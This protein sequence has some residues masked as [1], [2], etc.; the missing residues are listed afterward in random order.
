MNLVD[1]DSGVYAAMMAA[2]IDDVADAELGSGDPEINSAIDVI[3]EEVTNSTGDIERKEGQ[4]DEEYKQMVCEIVGAA[5]NRLKKSGKLDVCFERL[6]AISKRLGD[7]ICRAFTTLASDV[8]SDVEELENDITETTNAEMSADGLDDVNAYL[9]K[10][11]LNLCKWDTLFAKFG[12]EEVIAD[13]YKDITGVSPDYNVGRAIDIAE[14]HLTEIDNIEVDADTAK[15]IVDR[16]SYDDETTKPD[17][18]M[19]YKAITNKYALKDLTRNMYSY[20]IRKYHYGKAIKTFRV[21]CEKY[22]PLLQKFKKTALN[23][24][25]A[26]FDKMHKNM[27]K[28]LCVFELGAYTM[29][30]LR[31]DLYRANSVLL[32]EDVANEDVLNDMEENGNGISNEELSAYVKLHYTVPN[33]PLPSLGINGKDVKLFGKRAIEDCKLKHIELV[34][35][36]VRQQRRTM[37]SVAGDKLRAYVESLDDKFLPKGVARVDFVRGVNNT[38]LNRFN[39]MVFVNEDH[40]LQSCLYDFVLD[41][42]YNGTILKDIHKRYCELMT[43]KVIDAEDDT[44]SNEDLDGV[45]ST[46]ATELAVDFINKLFHK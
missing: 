18:E 32:D 16:V 3:T 42:K 35:D 30:A 7:N 36:A 24:S 22:L 41:T 40:N 28:V 14:S 29:A 6:D 37:K 9:P 15:E 12:G 21:C 46:V 17:V 1:V 38:S 39:K 31:K 8:S 11:N 4:T 33:R 25:D 26:T 5:Y 23:V 27:D 10:M 2:E 20:N 34:N 43:K 44:I 19:L 13:N 45:E